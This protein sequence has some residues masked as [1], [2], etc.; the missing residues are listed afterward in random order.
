MQS[1]VKTILGV[2]VFAAA[3]IGAYMLTSGPSK[4]RTREKQEDAT[5]V[6]TAS[7]TERFHVEGMTCD[8]CANG[9]KR[10]LEEVHGVIAAKVSFPDKE[11]KVQLTADGPSADAVMSIIKEAGYKVELA[12][13]QTGERVEIFHVEGMTCDG[14]ANGI[15]KKL[16]TIEGILT[17]DVSF[18]KK[19][20]KVRLAS[21]GPTAAKVA[22]II[23][24]E[25]YK[26]D[27][28]QVAPA[29]SEHESHNGGE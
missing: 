22:E 18:E 25:G 8:G 23:T 16:E 5:V 9:I 28:E 19:Q 13:D 20:A 6:K 3:F 14:C 2:V 15:K 1:A 12:S 10:K 11:A 27:K 7:R 26:V 17:A 29:E 4:D 21:D 24:A